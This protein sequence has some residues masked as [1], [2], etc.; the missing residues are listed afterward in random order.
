[1]APD[2]QPNNCPPK[3]SV[4]PEQTFSI[5]TQCNSDETAFNTHTPHLHEKSFKRPT[6][7][8]TPNEHLRDNIASYTQPQGTPKTQDKTLNLQPHNLPMPYLERALKAPPKSKSND[9]TYYTFSPTYIQPK[10]TPI[11]LD[12]ALNLQSDTLL[13]HLALKVPPESKQDD[14]TSYT[15]NQRFVQPQNTPETQ[16]TA[17]NLQ[18]QLLIAYHAN[19]QEKLLMERVKQT[20]QIASTDI[21]MIAKLHLQNR[22]LQELKQKLSSQNQTQYLNRLMKEN[23]ARRGLEW[24]I[25]HQHQDIFRKTMQLKKDLSKIYNV[26]KMLVKPPTP[27]EP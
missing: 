12:E 7:I 9:I 20:H 3:V 1:M 6:V 23:N 13:P 19:E 26:M 22:A 25:K 4:A 10:F 18:P 5:Q 21:V 24:L 2:Q 17:L 15:C 16:D 11:A 27:K 14:I 8:I